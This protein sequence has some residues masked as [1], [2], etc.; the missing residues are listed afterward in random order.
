MDPLL[1][2][3]A[4]PLL[5]YYATSRTAN[6]SFVAGPSG[7]GY[8]YPGFTPAAALSAHLRRTARAMDAT[9]MREV[10][11]LNSFTTY[12]PPYPPEVL[13][14]YV[15]AL[16]PRG[17]L[18]DY[19][20][21]A[22]T[23]D[24]WMEEGGG[25]A[26]AVV[27]TTHMWG[28]A[29]NFQGKVQAEVDALGPG[30]HFIFGA[31]YPWSFSPTDALRAI[32]TLRSRY[33]DRVVPVTTA[34]LIDLMERNF[35]VRAR[36][37]ARD[38][39]PFGSAFGS[40][41]SARSLVD[42]ADAAAASGDVP[43]AGYF[44]YKALETGQTGT[45]LVYSG[46]LVVL[47][48][49]ALIVVVSLPRPPRPS[50]K[51]PWSAAAFA[52]ATLGLLLGAR[53]VLRGNFWDYYPLGLGLVAG[54]LALRATKGLRSTATRVVGGA[55]E[56][57]SLALLPLTPI[58]FVPLAAG[59]ILVLAAHLRGNPTLAPDLILGGFVGVWAS[60]LVPTPY[61]VV[62]TALLAG[63]GALLPLGGPALGPRVPMNVARRG[64]LLTAIAALAALPVALLPLQALHSFFL[65]L[66]PLSQA[67]V[68][69][70]FILPGMALALA[71]ALV[72][73]R[74]SLGPSGLR[75]TAVALPMVSLAVFFSPAG[76]AAAIASLGLLTLFI[77]L[78]LALALRLPAQGL[79]PTASLALRWPAFAILAALLGTLP[80][81][82]YSL[83]LLPLPTSAEY[84]LYSTP[85]LLAVVAALVGLILVI[86]LRSGD[87]RAWR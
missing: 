22:S 24:Y 2:E 58:A 57:A 77:F 52:L 29:A 21:M 23:R 71:L 1:E 73:V 7:G 60:I 55:M 16:G 75:S 36:A 33:G 3:L 34:D 28:T 25:R 4:P 38:V 44:A 46:V 49:L 87:R 30:P 84:V 50:N 19:G 81:I 35:L 78:P 61:P 11:L 86:S 70:D 37:Q 43:R 13:Q 82:T 8:L 10:W 45:A 40:G 63:L 53:E 9:G 15:A 76:L 79:P 17:I 66:G 20:D 54:G 31:I 68:A 26:A 74:G 65:R 47:F 85:L 39:L 27:R 41:A 83:Y 72:R 69:L 59:S 80:G 6:D 51:P 5:D 64:P 18:L 14:A 67:A 48:A 42:Q 56:A 32:D 12:E 62:P